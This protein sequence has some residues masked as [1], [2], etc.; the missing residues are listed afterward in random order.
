M[1]EHRLASGRIFFEGLTRLGQALGYH[2]ESEQ[3]V[4]RRTTNPQ[5]VDIAWFGAPKQKFPLFIF[6]IESRPTNSM[7]NNATKIFGKPTST[8]EKPLFFF[9]IVITGGSTSERIDDLIGS[10]GYFNYGVYRISLGETNKLL[11]DIVNQHIRIR[12]SVN[13]ISIAHLL[14]SE[15]WSH[16]SREYLLT[17]IE[18]LEFSRTIEYILPSY[19]TLS[20]SDEFYQDQFTRYLKKVWQGD[21]LKPPKARFNTYF[22]SIWPALIYLAILASSEGDESITFDSSLEKYQGS[23]Y[24]PTTIGPHFGLDRDYDMFIIG[25]AP[26]YLALIAALMRDHKNAVR[27]ICEQVRIITD[28]LGGMSGV[29]SFISASWLLHISSADKTCFDIF[30]WA[31]C[32]I[33]ER[34]GAPQELVLKPTILFDDPTNDEDWMSYFEEGSSPEPVP[35]QN[36]FIRNVNAKPLAPAIRRRRAVTLGIRTLLDEP[37]RDGWLSSLVSVLHA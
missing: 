4:D 31:R 29:Y 23:S 30:N 21:V 37:G 7:A 17:H 28:Y 20:I 33:N 6:E 35:D 8:F 2:V 12:D 14:E 13:I 18:D 36:L 19:A 32:H 16:V 26:A 5:A 9:H 25:A 3:P 1:P 10:F 24:F 22:G 15:P 27:Y 34:G 11:T